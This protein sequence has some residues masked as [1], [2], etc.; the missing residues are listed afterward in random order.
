MWRDWWRAAGCSLLTPRPPDQRPRCRR[1][2]PRSDG[3]GVALYWV[4]DR[5]PDC[6]RTRRFVERCTPPVAR[7][8]GLSRYRIFRPIVRDA[9]QL[10]RD[11]IVPATGRVRQG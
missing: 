11:F 10:I 1:R 6:E 2:A 3:S 8:V 9:K 5:T 7:L 4:F